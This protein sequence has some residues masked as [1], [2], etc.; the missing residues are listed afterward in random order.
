MVFHGM[1]PDIPH[2]QSNCGEYFVEYCQFYIMLLW[3]LIMLCSRRRRKTRKTKKIQHYCMYSRPL[4][5]RVK[6]SD[7]EIMRAQKKSV[8]RLSQ[9]TSKLM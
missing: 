7:H 1:F 3:T 6:S 4:H 8:R 2:I 5:T 9:D